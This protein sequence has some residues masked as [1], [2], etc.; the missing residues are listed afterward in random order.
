MDLLLYVYQHPGPL[1]IVVNLIA[2]LLLALA[3]GKKGVV[4]GIVLGPV[5]GLVATIYLALV[6]KPAAMAWS[7][8]NLAEVGKATLMSTAMWFLAA[9]PGLLIGLAIRHLKRGQP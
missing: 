7:Q 4:A 8:I 6:G 5:W 1:L 2:T 3:W 9:I